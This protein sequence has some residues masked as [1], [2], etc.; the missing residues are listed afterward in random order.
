MTTDTPLRVGDFEVTADLMQAYVQSAQ[1]QMQARQRRVEARRE[2]AWA[3]ALEAAEML[4]TQYAAD[5]IALFGSLAGT[6]LFHERSDVDLAA[7]GMSEGDLCQAAG[8]L[9]SLDPDIAVDLIRAEEA[10]SSL[11]T[12]I[13]QQAI[14]L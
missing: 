5:R 1:A 12:V 4:R 11:L 10:P 13:E 8:R 7:W 3:V 9:L 2:R 6:T 14:D